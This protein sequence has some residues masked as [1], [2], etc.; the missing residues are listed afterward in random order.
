MRFTIE[1]PSHTTINSQAGNVAI[2]PDGKLVTF[3]VIDSS[4]N[5]RLWIRPIDALEAQMLPGTDNALL[6]FWS[7]DSRFIAFF[8]DGKLKKIPAAGGAVEALCDA[9]DGRGGTWG[10]DGTILFAPIAAGPIA[11]V[12]DTGG[13]P[14][15]VARPDSTK[16]ETSLRFPSFLPDGKHYLFLSLPPKRGQF[17]VFVSELGS[18]S[19]TLLTTSGGIP[20]YSAPYLIVSRGDRLMAQ[21]FD[22]GSRKLSGAPAPFASAPQLVGSAGTAGISASENGILIRSSAGLQDTQLQW[23]DANGHPGAVIPL[24]PAK[25]GSLAISPDGQRAVVERYSDANSMDLWMVDLSR[26]LPSRFTHLAS[27]HIFNETWSPDGSRIAFNSDADGPYDIYEMDANGEGEEH[28]L[29]HSSSPFKNITQWTADGRYLL[30][31]QPD[32]STGWDVWAVP[33]SGE[34]KPFPVVRGRYNEQSGHM[35]PDGKWVAFV[36]DESGRPEVYVTSFPT[37]GPRYQVST[38]G[39]FFANWAPD[40]KSLYFVS[41]DGI[42]YV[43]QLQMTPSFRA[44]TPR[45][46]FKTRSDVVGVGVTKNLD[47]YIQ[48]VPVGQASPAAVTVEV[49]WAAALEK[50]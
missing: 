24:P 10:K 13:D 1:A 49:N 48:V 32:P 25:Y 4:G 9:G 46:L 50:H 7:P 20:V 2:S 15:I 16:G 23:L 18:S 3:G 44:S 29:Y 5:L 38:G 17:S 41:S 39:A 11:R 14:L 45:I 33:T 19:R 35:S 36:S 42:T 27:A 40:G 47:R 30:F 12:S 43:S 6:P 26:A 22:P 8:A 28:V 37:P 31:D 21:R 34:A